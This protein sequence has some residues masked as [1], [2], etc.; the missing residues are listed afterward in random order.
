M[1]V[2]FV[3]RMCFASAI[4]V[5][6][7]V[8][9]LNLPWKKSPILQN[10]PR[11][12]SFRIPFYFVLYSGLWSGFMN[13]PPS[14]FSNRA[15]KSPQRGLGRQL[16][17]WRYQRNFSAPSWAPNLAQCV[18]LLWIR[19]IQPIWFASDLLWYSVHITP[20]CPRL[21]LSVVT[22]FLEKGKFSDRLRG[23]VV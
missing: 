4:S 14:V 13:P 5:I 12:L 15:R 3:F 1:P 19:L 10:F 21:F 6:T 11:T 8:A 17:R 23:V 2:W 7:P 18:V 22:R 16:E 9:R 20:P